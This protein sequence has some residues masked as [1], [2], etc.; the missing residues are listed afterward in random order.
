MNVAAMAGM[1][2][3]IVD[4]AEAKAKQF[5]AAS[6]F[7]LITERVASQRERTRVFQELCNLAEQARAAQPPQPRR[8]P[9]SSLPAP[10]LPPSPPLHSLASPETNELLLMLR[11]PQA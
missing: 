5:E 8:S 1:P 10:S 4:Q 7:G 11:S 2:V 6:Q 3:S 9:R